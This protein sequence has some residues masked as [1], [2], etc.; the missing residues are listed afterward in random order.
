MR[1]LPILIVTILAGE[2]TA[3][4]LSGNGEL[5]LVIAR[6]N[7]ST[8]TLNAKLALRREGATWRHEAVLSALYSRKDGVD[9]AD[10]QELA[11][12]SDFRREQPRYGFAALRLEQDDFAAYRWQSSV[13]AGLGWRVLA[14]E[15]RTLALEAGPGLRRAAPQGG[16]AVEEDLILRASLDYRQR[17]SETAE[18]FDET[19]IET[20]GDNTH[21]KN[22]LGLRLRINDRLALKASLALRHNTTAPAG[23]RRTDSLTSLNLAYEF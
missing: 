12:K 17:L 8:E 5:G 15:G 1:L 22:D 20:G 21:L 19:L 9:A 18:L 6:G 16:G 14:K 2:D 7:S 4:A 23:A 11:L 3:P 10:R 13:A